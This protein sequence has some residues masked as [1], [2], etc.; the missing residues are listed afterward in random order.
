MRRLRAAAEDS[1]PPTRESANIAVSRVSERDEALA[2][3]LPWRRV[4]WRQDHLPLYHHFITSTVFRLFRGDHVNFWRD[5][6]AQMSFEVDVIFDALLAISAAHRSALLSCMKS[7]T[8]E[9]TKWKV[10]GLS[11]YG[12]TLRSI[13]NKG[14]NVMEAP[15]AALKA[16][17]IALL[18]LSYFEVN[19]PVC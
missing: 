18:F 1:Q 19:I 16:K 3:E 6:V 13:V 11:A 15:M 12:R 8:Q 4:N 9:A 17:L 7:N 5:E 14:C 2:P 10:M